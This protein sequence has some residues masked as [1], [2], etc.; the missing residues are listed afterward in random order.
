MQREDWTSVLLWK[1]WL[2]Y[3]ASGQILMEIQ[4]WIILLRVIDSSYLALIQITHSFSLSPSLSALPSALLRQNGLHGIG[5]RWQIKGQHRPASPKVL[6][7]GLNCYS[8]FYPQPFCFLTCTEPWPETFPQSHALLS[9]RLPFPI[10]SP[11]PACALTHTH[12]HILTCIPV[13]SK[14]VKNR[15][16]RKHSDLIE[17]MYW[18]PKSEPDLVWGQFQF[19]SFAVTTQ[20]HT[21]IN[22]K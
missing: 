5:K 6:A 21:E 1:A 17:I 22:F 19:M 7:L 14:C 10:S 3:F 18:D 12:T 11:L 13:A 20:Y 8:H 16:K 2:R 9:P 4:T 15:E